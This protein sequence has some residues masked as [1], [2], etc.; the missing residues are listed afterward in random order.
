MKKVTASQNFFPFAA[1]DTYAARTLATSSSRKLKKDFYTTASIED[2]TL[3]QEWIK[4]KLL[5]NSKP[6]IAK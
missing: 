4:S 3:D 2:I 1:L 6:F 5:L